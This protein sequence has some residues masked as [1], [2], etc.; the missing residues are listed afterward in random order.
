MY[1]HHSSA[2]AGRAVA[3]LE[4]PRQRHPRRRH[5]PRLISYNITLYDDCPKTD[6]NPY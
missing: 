5:R 2:A 3:G 6:P 4:A 1:N